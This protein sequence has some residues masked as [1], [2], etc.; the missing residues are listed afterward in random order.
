MIFTWT[1]ESESQTGRQLK[2]SLKFG[3]ETEEVTNSSLFSPPPILSNLILSVK[4]Y[5]IIFWKLCDLY[6]LLKS[7]YVCHSNIWLILQWKS[8]LFL[9]CLNRAYHQHEAYFVLPFKTAC[10]L[11]HNI[12]TVSTLTYGCS[13]K[14]ASLY[15]EPLSLLQDNLGSQI[16]SIISLNFGIVAILFTTLENRITTFRRTSDHVK[17]SNNYS[18]ISQLTVSVS[19]YGCFNFFLIL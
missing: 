2:C 5:K 15:Y 13:G 9:L 4:E 18:S 6:W 7:L 16:F 14:P 19:C 11:C 3:T 17:H 12:K 10:C 1:T 8:Q